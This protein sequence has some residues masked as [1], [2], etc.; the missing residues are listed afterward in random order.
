MVAAVSGAT[1]VGL[2]AY[3][4]HAFRPKDPA[5]RD[6]FQRGNDYH[7]LHS[8]LLAAAP[9]ARRPNLVNSEPNTLVL[10]WVL[11]FSLKSCRL[12]VGGLTSVGILLFSGTCYVVGITENRANSTLAPFGGFALIGAWLA[13]A[14]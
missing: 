8:L 3:N 12:Q 11:L 6:V 4:A 7:L 14:L 9:V 13:L 5:F 2:G 1:A 10:L